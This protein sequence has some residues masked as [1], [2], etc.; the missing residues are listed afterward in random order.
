M[1]GPAWVGTGR[2]E[3]M[4]QRGRAGWRQWG[5]WPFFSGG[6]WVEAS[7]GQGGWGRVFSKKKNLIGKLTASEFL[8]WLSGNQSD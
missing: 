6:W 1:Q 4:G 7:G 5:P 3:A 8:W 2:R